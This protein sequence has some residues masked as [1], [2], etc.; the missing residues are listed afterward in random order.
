VRSILLQQFNGYLST[1]GSN[2]YYIKDLTWQVKQGEHWVLLGGN[3]A[4]KSA[5]GATLI[6]EAKQQSGQRHSTFNN[7]QLVS[8]DLQKQLLS[9]NRKSDKTQKVTDILFSAPEINNDLCQQLITALNFD[10]LLNRNFTD[11]STGETRK[12][13]LIKAL[14]AN[15]D[16]VVLDEPFDGLD[17][18]STRQLNRLLKQ[19]STHTCFVFVLNRVDETP[20]FVD[21]FAYV[22]KGLLQ[23]SL[24]KP[25]AAERADLFKLLHLE[26]TPIT[27]PDSPEPAFIS[28]VNT[29]LV[30]L[31]D[32]HVRYSEQTIFE[33]LNWTIKQHQHWQ[34]TGK[35]GSG[36]TCLL[37]LITGDNPQCYNNEIEV[38]GFKRGTG[39]SISA[40]N[41][42]ISGFFDSIGL[43]QQANEL[44]MRLAKQWLALIGLSDKANCAFTQLSYGDQRLL[45]IVR[46][47][48]KHPALVILDEPCLGLDEANRQRVLLL[49]EKVCAAKTSTV[50]YVN[51]H[52]ADTIKG[53]EHTLKMEDF[54]PTY[55][56]Q[57]TAHSESII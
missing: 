49:I 30:K 54:K 41:T 6:G 32:A 25:C 46:A 9:A 27:I 28:N 11:L 10:A 22:S 44:Q 40:L 4:G 23:H 52:A 31:T 2:R 26:H 38:F 3:G 24:A 42:V 56:E 19:L 12:L 51:H 48:V 15:S 39:E 8:S 53:I 47:M 1:G 21:H 20:A 29:P 13:L 7:L 16:L 50:I 33:N 37:N 14:S 18:E 57:H 17:T 43:Y 55:Y 5:L 34:L 35:N 36:K 45:L